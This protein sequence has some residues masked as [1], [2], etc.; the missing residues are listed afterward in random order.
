[1]IKISSNSTIATKLSDIID[2]D[3]G[4]AISGNATLE[5]LADS[6]MELILDTASGRYQTHAQRLGQDDFIPWKRGVSL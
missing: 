4:P 2:F 1:M 6:L 5:E 3:T